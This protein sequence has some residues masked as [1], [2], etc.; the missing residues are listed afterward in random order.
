MPTYQSQYTGQQID[1]AVGAINSVL[2]NNGFVSVNGLETTLE[3]YLT[4]SDASS[5]YLTQNNASST[6]VPLKTTSDTGVFLRGDNTWSNTITLASGSSGEFT[7]SRGNISL[8]MGIGTGDTN[9]GLFS[10]A[11]NNW[12]VYCDGTNVYLNGTA[13]SVARAS[14]GNKDYCSHDCNAITSNGMW[15]YNSNG[16]ATSI[17]ASTTDG[18]LYSQAYSD[19]WVGQIAQDYRNGNLFVRGKN[20]GTWT[21]WNKVALQGGYG[22][23]RGTASYTFDASNTS[24]TL[25]VTFTTHGRPVFIA[26]SGDLNPTTADVAWMTIDLYSDSTQLCRQIAQ[27]NANS[28]NI[29]FHCSYLT[30]CAAG[31]HTFKVVFTRG[32][33]TFTLSEGGAIQA[34][35]FSVFEI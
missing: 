6:Y 34:P 27:S 20:S 2:E 18:A 15:Y 8:W 4:T 11:I 33:G 23:T 13:N 10:D 26:V 14:F 24:R 35:N 3:N 5:T 21:S 32:A 28:H 17:G 30:S 19:I 22:G 25:S 31:S 7:A 29:P 16:P 1:A 12:M 9:H